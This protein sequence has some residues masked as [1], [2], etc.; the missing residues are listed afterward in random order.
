MKSWEEHYATRSERMKAS[1]IRELLK[2]LD[3]PDI[4]SFAGGIPDPNLFPAS[5]FEPAY[6]TVLRSELAQSAL[7][8]SVSEGYLPLREWICGY[9]AD[10]D[11]ECTPENVLITSGS[12]QGL[13]YLGKLFLSPGDTALVEWPTYLGALQAFNAYEPNFD[14]L[15]L[16]TNRASGDFHAR[17]TEVGGAVKFAYACTDFVNPTG[18]TMNI[19][20][21][22][23]LLDL[24]EALD[25]VVIEDA[26]YHALRYDGEPVAPV[27]SRDIARGGNIDNTRTVFCGTFS[28]TLTPGLRVG[29]MVAAKEII[30]K[31]VLIKQASDLHSPSI[32]Q[33]V[34]DHVA[35]ACFEQQVMKIRNVYRE[36]RDKMLAM[37]E[38]HMPIGV[39]WS[40][41]E[42]GMFIWVTLPM[43]LDGAELLAVSI[44]TTKVAFVPGSAFFAD[45]SG[46]N[47]IRLSFS[48]ATPEMIDTGIGALGDLITQSLA[49]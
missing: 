4:I 47:T 8:Y 21:R 45:G 11:V 9:M 10:A 34:V 38:R 49:E 43:G 3:Q 14:R 25:I 22:E 33:M 6:S 30:S 32:N 24:A 1:E 36:R 13:D 44:K 35:R 23:Q 42:G 5:E 48:C 17:A 15:D 16:K 39:E 29:W 26:A 20:A 28:K 40:H 31:L 37:L 7:Q 18:N 46:R 12:Q 2:L 19:A 27:L 41:P